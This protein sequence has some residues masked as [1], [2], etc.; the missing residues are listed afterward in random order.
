MGAGWLAESC[1][2]A[3]PGGE[4]MRKTAIL[5]ATL[6]L[7]AVFTGSALAQSSVP[8][9]K[10]YGAVEWGMSLQQVLAAEPRAV[11][12]TIDRKSTRLNSSH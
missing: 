5:V 6:T 12:Y 11:E 2:L 9:V 1:G 3:E 4:A 8:D 10:G 7:S